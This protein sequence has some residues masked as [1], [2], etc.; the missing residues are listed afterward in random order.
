VG[1]GKE[2]AGKEITRTRAL[3]NMYCKVRA[4]G[5]SS[6]RFYLLKP[7]R[8]PALAEASRAVFHHFLAH[9]KPRYPH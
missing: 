2:A 4:G 8:N 5:K 6:A 7:L 1:R 9:F 3:L